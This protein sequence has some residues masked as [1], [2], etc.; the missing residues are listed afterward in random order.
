MILETFW[1]ILLAALSFWIASDGSTVRGILAVVLAVLLVTA[2]AFVIAVYFACLSVVKKAVTDA[3]LGRTIFDALFEYAL[4]VT[5]D[6]PEEP[7]TAK[8][9]THM[10]REGVERKLNDAA[11]HI[12][13]DEAPSTKW[14]GLL[15]WLAKQVQRICIWA[16][17]KVITNSC[18]RDGTSV[19]LVELR[20]R[21]ASTIDDGLIAHLRQYVTR[22][23]FTL[24]STVSS[25]ACLI[26]LGIRQLPL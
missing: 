3:G 12:L 13:A 9:P 1:G 7:S 11:R 8:I 26:S 6:D 18:S 25:L 2:C 22:L 14:A 5:G 21:L 23:T 24:I 19:N 20:D 4:G 10:S 16:T 17:V 15:F